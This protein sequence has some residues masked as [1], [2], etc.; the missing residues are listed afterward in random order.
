MKLWGN[1]VPMDVNA[2]ENRFANFNE[3]TVYPSPYVVA[4]VHGYT[5]HYYA[6]T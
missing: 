3:Y 4:D 2:S 5:K 1:T 6:G